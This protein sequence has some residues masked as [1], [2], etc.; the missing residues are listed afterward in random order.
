MDNKCANINLLR[1][2]KRLTTHV[3]HQDWSIPTWVA[4]KKMSVFHFSNIFVYAPAYFTFLVESGGLLKRR[5]L[6]RSFTVDERR[7]HSP[8]VNIIFS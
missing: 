8:K 2:I 6:N 7:L 3:K 5:V 1:N 4:I